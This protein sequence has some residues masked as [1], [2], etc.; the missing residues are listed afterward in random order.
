MFDAEGH[1]RQVLVLDEEVD[2]FDF[3]LFF[4]VF[5]SHALQVRYLKPVNLPR[6]PSHLEPGQVVP[7]KS[8]DLD[9]IQ[10]EDDG[11]LN[12]LVVLEAGCFDVKSVEAVHIQLLGLLVLLGFDWRLIVCYVPRRRVFPGT[13][14][15]NGANA[16][17]LEVSYYF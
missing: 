12:W 1:D 8:F 7:D 16:S 17:L 3:L 2:Q 5:G 14:L 10:I 4:E 9:A 11:N 6:R 15:L 13:N